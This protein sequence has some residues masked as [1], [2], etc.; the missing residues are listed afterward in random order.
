GGRGSWHG[1]DGPPPAGGKQLGWVD[2]TAAE[3]STGSGSL[4]FTV[5]NELALEGGQEIVIGLR[6]LHLGN[7]ALTI[8]AADLRQAVEAGAAIARP[9]QWRLFGRLTPGRRATSET[10]CVTVRH[11]APAGWILYCGPPRRPPPPRRYPLDV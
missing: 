9:R 2:F 5:P 6:F 8:R 11:S 4:D 1:R 3:L 10:H 7:A